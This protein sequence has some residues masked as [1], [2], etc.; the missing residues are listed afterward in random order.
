M[1]RD[2]YGMPETFFFGQVV[3]EWDSFWL[4]PIS[5]EMERPAGFG[6]VQ[7]SGSQIGVAL[8]TDDDFDIVTMKNFAVE[9][10]RFATD[11]LSFVLGAGITAH[12]VG[13]YRQDDGLTV[14]DPY[15]D[16][17][18]S[19][20]ERKQDHGEHLSQL[21]T[22]AA[23]SPAVRFA[24]G[25]IREAIIE[26][27]DTGYLCYRA[28]ESLRQSLLE[29]GSKDEGAARRRSWERLRQE[30]GVPEAD[31]RRLSELGGVRR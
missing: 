20:D 24:L 3:P 23:R 25:D 22:A 30:V 4:S 10:A 9:L 26:P 8:S 7:I 31:S 21:V 29:G 13:A 11:A 17:V 5:V 12:L 15:F 6:S 14:F 2:A 18:V 1:R 28:V 19:P 27:L 16:A